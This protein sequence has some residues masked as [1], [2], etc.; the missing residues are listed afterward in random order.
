MRWVF[1]VRERLRDLL[2][3]AEEDAAMQEELEFHLE[4]EAA[5]NV[6]EGMSPGEARRR[7]RLAFGGVERVKEEVREARDSW[8][9]GRFAQD[10]RYSLR[11]LGRAPGF[12]LTSV[13]ALG[14]GIGAATAVFSV[15]DGVLLKPLPVAEQEDLLVVSW[16]APDRDMEDLPFSY[17]AFESMRDGL[18]AVSGLAAHPYAGAL[19]ATLH[20]DDGSATQ[21]QVAPVTGEWF[22]VLG[23]VPMAGRL[24]GREDD[25]IGAA[26]ALILAASVAERLFGD[27]ASAV[28]ERLRLNAEVHTVV[29]VAPPGFAYP[30]GVEAWAGATPYVLSV[31]GGESLHDAHRIAW[32][33]AGRLAP[34]RTI[35]Q[36]RA[37]LESELRRVNAEAGWVGGQR[38]QVV[39]FAEVV[40]GE[41]RATVL[42]LGGAV[43][44]VLLVAGVNVANLLLVRGITR[45]RELVVRAAIGASRSRL[46]RQLATEGAVLMTG[47]V[48][49]ALIVAYGG[50]GFLLS[51][52]PEELP[53]LDEIGIDRRALAFS[54]AAALVVGVVFGALPAL[55]TVDSGLGNGL[56]ARDEGAATG[57]RS[58]RLRHGLVVGQVA[59]TVVILSLAGLLLRSFERIQRLELGFAATDIVLAEV[60]IPPLTYAEPAQVQRAMV[61][62]A[63]R[64][65]EVPGVT[66][67]TAVVA[68]PFSGTQGV[69]ALWYGEGQVLDGSNV[70][71][72]N[73]E[74][75]D[76]GY[77][78][79]L[80]IPLLRGRV[81]DEGDRADSER[82]VVV[83]DAFARLYWPTEDPVGRRIKA[84]FSDSETPWVTVVGLVGDSRYRELTETR[85]TVY[86]PYEQ[87]IPVTP[88]Y[89]AVSTA[90]PEGVAASIRAIVGREEPGAAVVRLTALPRLLAEPLAHPRFQSVL[91]ASFAFVGLILSAIGTYGVLAFLVRQR[92]REI[93]V[94]MALGANPSHLRRL[95]IGQG[96]MIGVI[97][98]L[99]GSVAAIAAGRAIESLLLDVTPWDPVVLVA[100]AAILLLACLAAAAL[101]TRTATRLDPMIV[102]R[103]D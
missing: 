41:V 40:V 23:V 2:G 56:R 54:A 39:P 86:V 59:L 47:G 74:G 4:S 100:T 82:V 89:L 92:S 26:P 79:T 80:R 35:E 97:G 85:P 81:I 68:R 7:A 78:S 69:D 102:M 84:G 52:A 12:T 13:L 27:P 64:V 1:Q 46:L 94:R 71:Y 98:V 37:E 21:L 44:L 91:T 48:I 22:D 60:A 42:M 33:L 65:S 9:I 36:A 6:A 57:V 28:G 32:Y 30:Q 75:V 93:G 103:G 99:I 3:R 43:L 55:R 63:E 61:R 18:G 31:E 101:P 5:K 51:L 49:L 19:G 88:R 34:G 72:T 29:G 95:V 67:A 50:L 70:P 90:A 76:P 53:R 10:V 8:G 20:L 25:R 87:G 11:T 66:R 38:I 16:A 58:R 96:L 45:R 62:L 77:F 17:A 14:L 15:V 73:Y 24:I 83:N